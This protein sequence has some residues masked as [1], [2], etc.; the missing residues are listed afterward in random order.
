MI[1]D[2]E[3]LR[4]YPDVFV[5]QW[6]L[7]H[8]QNSIEFTLLPDR[9][10]LPRIENVKIHSARISGVNQKTLDV[11]YDTRLKIP[12]GVL[13]LGIM[14]IN[15]DFAVVCSVSPFLPPLYSSLV[16]QFFTG[17]EA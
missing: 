1:I 13:Y 17:N 3:L 5:T 11:L 4:D 10:N 7:P 16:G 14:T 2:K 9:H 15:R 12:T 8:D 6:E